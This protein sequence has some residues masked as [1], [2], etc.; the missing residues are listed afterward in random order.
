MTAASA[1]NRAA[2]VICG[3]DGSDES[4]SAALIGAVLAGAFRIDAVAVHAYTEP[5]TPHGSQAERERG[6]HASRSRALTTLAECALKHGLDFELEARPGEP[7]AV[8]EAVAA[9]RAAP[10]VAVGSRG[11][12]PFGAA[13]FGSVSASLIGSGRQPVLVV[14]PSAAA[15]RTLAGSAVACVFD[16]A[17][18]S[19]AAT[20]FA[21]R[22]SDRLGA[23][24]VILHARAYVPAAAGALGGV[25]IADPELDSGREAIERVVDRIVHGA[26]VDHVEAAGVAAPALAEAAKSEDASL[27]VVGDSGHGNAVAALLGPPSRRLAAVGPLPVVAVPPPDEPV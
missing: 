13:V 7:A 21:A 22:L 12:G 15:L 14:P 3:V 1:S 23:R 10:L 9:E 24:L 27:I 6:R 5:T 19:R 26:A 4:L 11:R 17:P 20:A 18:E 25:P 2:A 8:I 16:G